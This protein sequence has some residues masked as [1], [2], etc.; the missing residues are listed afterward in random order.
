M[1]NF[2]AIVIIIIIIYFFLIV[3]RKFIKRNLSGK[4]SL[5]IDNSYFIKFSNTIRQK[6]FHNQVESYIFSNQEKIYLRKKMISLFKGSKEEK[7]EALNIAKKLSDKSTL[8]I[9]RMGL[10][11]MDSDIV[12]ISANLISRFK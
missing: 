4:I 3:K 11:D 10:K 9:L 2:L 7:L 6:N 8:I 1:I 12:K 5:P